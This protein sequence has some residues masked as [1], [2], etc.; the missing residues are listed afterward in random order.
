MIKV[1]EKIDDY[2]EDRLISIVCV[3]EE[4]FYLYYFFDKY[5]M[6]EFVKFKVPR[7][8]EVETVV[9]RYPSADYFEREIHDFYG[10]SFEGNPNMHLK[11]FLPENWKGKPPFLKERKK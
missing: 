4:E 7:G 8:E 6:I 10:I 9:D 1:K 2:E 3:K 11:L 5:G